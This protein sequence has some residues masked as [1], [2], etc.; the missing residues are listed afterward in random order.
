MYDAEYTCVCVCARARRTCSPGILVYGRLAMSLAVSTGFGMLML[1]R[2]VA[3]SGR[4]CEVA[5]DG[6]SVDARDTVLDAID[7]F[8]IM[9]FTL[10]LFGTKWT[11]ESATM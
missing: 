8:N 5:V 11:V 7:R 1:R 2:Y 9:S 10:S 4:R 3:A 6:T